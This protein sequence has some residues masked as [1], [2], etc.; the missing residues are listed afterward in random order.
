MRRMRGDNRR[1]A[2]RRA[3]FLSPRRRPGRVLMSDEHFTVDGTLLESWASQKSFQRND[4]GDDGDG[5]HFHGQT[6]PTTRMRRPPIPRPAVSQVAQ[7]RVAAGVS[8]SSADRESARLDRRR[9]ADAGRRVRPCSSWRRLGVAPAAASRS[10]LT[11]AMI[12]MAAFITCAPAARRHTS[13]RTTR[14]AGA[15]RLITA[16]RVTSATPRVSTRGRA[17]NRPSG[18]SSPSACFGR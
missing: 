6:R 9:V 10:A 14:D 18:G 5:R 12:R 13:A 3:Q 17:S 1:P 15:V 11:R 4:G 16:R 2:G 8:R 7:H